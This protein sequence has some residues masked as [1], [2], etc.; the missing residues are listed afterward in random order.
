MDK[1]FLLHAFGYGLLLWLFG[2]I[3]GF[4][5]FA[6]LPQNLLGWAIMPFGI[7]LALWIL[8]KKIKEKDLEYYLSIAIVWLVIAVTFDYVFL[9]KLL[10]PADY[11]RL[12]V[13]IYYGLTFLLPLLVWFKKSIKI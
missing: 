9:V 11:Y 4:V 8:F 3:L 5:F 1:K 13:F 6:F 2:Y 12:D 10:H 7:A